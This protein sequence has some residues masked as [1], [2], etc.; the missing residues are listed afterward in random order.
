VIS[1]FMFNFLSTFFAGVAVA[2]GAGA[3]G[4]AVAAVAAGA[5]G[6]AGTTGVAAKA[7][8]VTKVAIRVAIVFISSF[9]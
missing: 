5:A 1:L 6:V 2:A 7:V 8:V 9:L 3:A 4:V